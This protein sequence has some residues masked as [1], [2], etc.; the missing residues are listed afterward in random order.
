MLY[1]IYVSGDNDCSVL[2]V[3]AG[4]PGLDDGMLFG[5]RFLPCMSVGPFMAQWCGHWVLHV[6]GSIWHGVLHVF[7]ST[8]NGVLH[9]CPWFYVCASCFDSDNVHTGV[10]V[11]GLGYWNSQ[12]NHT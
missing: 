8:W 3:L 11:V 12:L 5:R 9:V 4:V 10:C 2:G 1:I 7:G 6:F